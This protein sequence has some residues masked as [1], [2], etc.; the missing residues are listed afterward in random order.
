[1]KQFRIVLAVCVAVGVLAPVGCDALR[2]LLGDS[3][4]AVAYISVTPPRRSIY[5]NDEYAVRAQ[6][7]MLKNSYVLFATEEAVLLRA[8]NNDVDEDGKKLD[9]IR[10][11]SWFT[12]DPNQ[13]VKQLRSELSVVPVP[14]TLLI[15]LSLR[16]PDLQQAV[17]VVNAVADAMVHAA[18]EPAKHKRAE[19]IHALK[20]RLDEINTSLASKQKAIDKLRGQSQAPIVQG[21]RELVQAILQ[22][23]TNELTQLRLL[24]TQAEKTLSTLKEQAASG[25][26]AESTT[27]KQKLEADPTYRQLLTNLKNLKIELNSL[28]R[29]GSH[30][31]TR[32]T[33]NRIELVE[34]NIA[35]MKRDLT[36]KFIKEMML[37]Q[38]SQVAAVDERL[39]AVEKQYNQESQK[40]KTLGVTLTKIETLESEMKRLEQRAEQ[41][42]TALIEFRI[43]LGDVPLRVHA[44]AEIPVKQ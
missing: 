3:H 11:T 18:A 35:E 29:L 30:R 37:K 8:L 14:D 43:A 32:A 16:G 17:Q 24:K 27:I 10:K 22:S 9:R 20:A 36:E 4:T 2:N 44:Y 31:R 38:E 5:K 26:L 21:G 19:R 33:Q 15:R 23:W 12:G 40:L 41:I 42:E 13:T 28:N 25:R 6:L 39:L 7:D 1:M 34:Q